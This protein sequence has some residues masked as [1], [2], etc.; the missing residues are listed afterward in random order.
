MKGIALNLLKKF[1]ITYTHLRE[2]NFKHIIY[3]G[4]NKAGCFI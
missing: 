2:R 3:D 4:E 1:G